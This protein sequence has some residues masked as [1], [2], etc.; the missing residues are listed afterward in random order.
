MGTADWWL[1]MLMIVHEVLTQST[2][3]RQIC[4][5]GVA[6][7]DIGGFIWNFVLILIIRHS[8]FIAVPCDH[9][10]MFYTTSHSHEKLC[11]IFEEAWNE[12]RAWSLPSN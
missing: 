3:R 9:L 12:K 11:E 6:I 7:G 1:I 4:C 5:I 10:I 8:Y 2:M